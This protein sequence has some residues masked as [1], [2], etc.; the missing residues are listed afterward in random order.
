TP[1]STGSAR[2]LQVTGVGGVPGGANT[3]VLNVTV[4]DTAAPSY[5]TVWP[6]GQVRPLASNLNW[7]AG[8]TRPNPA[9]AKVG[10]GGKVSIFNSA[11]STSVIADVV[12]YFAS[13]SS[14]SFQAMTPRRLLDS[15]DGTGG[16]SSPWSAG[17]TRTLTVAGIAGVPAN[18]TAVI[19]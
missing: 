17:T 14:A 12:G 11:G 5:L 2:D 4:T 8:D 16:Y 1:W 7:P 18:A 15:R 10:T 3:V 19:L 6:T 13:G 9:V